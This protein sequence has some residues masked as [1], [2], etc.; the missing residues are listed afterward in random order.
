MFTA[1]VMFCMVSYSNGQP[2]CGQLTDN[3]GPY[4][5]RQRC[6]ARTA[7]MRTDFGD[8]LR[9]QGFRGEAKMKR[10]CRRD[11]SAERI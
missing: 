11:R 9:T 2:T 4:E 1:I 3:R 6:N 8:A 7:E 5:T 10:V